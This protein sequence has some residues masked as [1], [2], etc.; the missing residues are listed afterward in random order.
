MDMFTAQSA[1]DFA[2]A[3]QLAFMERCLNLLRGFFNNLLSFEAIRQNLKRPIPVD[4]RLQEIKLDKI[5]GSVNKF[6]SRDFSRTFLPKSSRNKDR[7]RRVDDLFHNQWIEP[8]EVYKV[9][10]VYFVRDGH[11]RISIN[12]THG[13]NTIEAYV[14]EYKTE[15]PIDKYDDLLILLRKGKYALS[16][17]AIIDEKR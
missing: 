11:H 10:Q 8:I 3:Q 13:I 17:E 5:V 4:K 16:H 6:K 9:G 2:K 15:V 14:T 7:W 12:R 1:R